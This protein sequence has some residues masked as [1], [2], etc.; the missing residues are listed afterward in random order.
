MTENDK[1]DKTICPHCGEK[2][3]KWMPPPE[4][5]WGLHYQYVC[6][7]DECPYYKRGWKHMMDNFQQKAS[8]RHRYNPQNDESGPLPVWSE[9]ALKNAIIKE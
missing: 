7:N 2:M 6:F 8:Y 4:S 1:Q 9:T 5:S 3:F